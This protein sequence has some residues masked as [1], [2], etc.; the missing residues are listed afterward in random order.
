MM[1]R[2]N[3]HLWFKASSAIAGFIP[4]IF[5][6]LITISTILNPGYDHV[7]ST[8]SRLAIESNYSWIAKAAISIYGASYFFISWP[9][10]YI[11]QSRNQEKSAY[12]VCILLI[13][14]SFF[15]LLTGLIP[16][17]IDRGGIF[18]THSSGGISISGMIHDVS[19]RLSFICGITAI[20]I[21]SAASIRFE[22]NRWLPIL[23]IL[24]VITMLV[25]GGIFTI[26]I[27]LPYSHW[28]WNWIGIFQKVIV[29][30]S[31]IWIQ[32]I[33]IRVF[34]EIRSGQL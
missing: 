34:I 30:S 20:S 17:D 5:I 2:E 31:V 8:I 11:L 15:S 28:L 6:I 1:N 3:V 13:F 26:T 32:I 18:V 7:R 24:T 21:F 12:L 16:D 23:S 25:A 22:K 27:M 10:Y 9:L 14:V 19:S 4:L 33:S 29:L